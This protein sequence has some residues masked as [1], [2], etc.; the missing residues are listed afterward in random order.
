MRIYE[1]RVTEV[2]DRIVLVEAEGDASAKYAAESHRWLDE[3][4][5]IT[6]NVFVEYVRPQGEETR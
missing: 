5:P 1:C 2:I 3:Q 6:A 4:K